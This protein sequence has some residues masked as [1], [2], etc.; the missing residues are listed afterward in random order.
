MKEPSFLGHPLEQKGHG[1]GNLSWTATLYAGEMRIQIHLFQDG[2]SGMFHAQA[3]FEK[4][5]YGDVHFG[6]DHYG[7]RIH[8]GAPTAGMALERLERAYR[9]FVSNLTSICQSPST[10][11][12]NT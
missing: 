6:G 3:N 11:A 12:E 2:H 8:S 4:A 5:S 9:D 10:L 1:S 7:M